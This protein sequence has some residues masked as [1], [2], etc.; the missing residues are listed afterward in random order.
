MFLVKYK[1][2]IDLPHYIDV[3]YNGHQCAGC[4]QLIQ[5]SDATELLTIVKDSISKSIQLNVDTE[6][7]IEESSATQGL[8]ELSDL[9]CKIFDC[10]N[11]TVEN[12]FHE[13]SDSNG[14]KKKQFKIQFKPIKIGTHRIEIY[15]LN[16][17]LN[18][19]PLLTE[20]FNINKVKLQPI[21]N[22]NFIVNEK[23]FLS[24]KYYFFE[25]IR[26][27]LKTSFALNS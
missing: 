12:R 25:L 1:P 16:N 26:L 17:H 23:I 8:I 22:T 15:Y 5:I 7:L 3:L 9:T 19:S 20:C 21:Q 14:T 24:R 4:P 18:G 13:L 11:K 27:V 6:I 10:D 2:E